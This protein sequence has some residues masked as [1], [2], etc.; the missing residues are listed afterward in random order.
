MRTSGHMSV[1]QGKRVVVWMR[2]GTKFIAQFKEH[3]SRYIIFFDHR[4]VRKE[5]VST[6]SLHKGNTEEFA[7]P[8][9]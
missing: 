7:S 9:S 5:A 2:D 3:K 4:S 6:L 1:Q 8:R